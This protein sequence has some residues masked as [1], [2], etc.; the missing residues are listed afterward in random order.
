VPESKVL[1]FADSCI[2]CRSCTGGNDSW[3]NALLW[4]ENTLRVD[5]AAVADWDHLVERC[6]TQAL[7]WDSYDITVGELVAQLERDAVF[8]RNGGGITLSGGEPL[9][10]KDFSCAVLRA[11]KERGWGTAIETSLYADAATVDA[12]VPLADTVFADCKIRDETE[13]KAATSVSN[14]V[15]LDNL[16]R[17][18]CGEYAAR[19]IVRTPL[20]PDYTACEDNIAAI[21]RFISGLYPPVR[22]EL[23]NYNPLAAGKY[24]LVG[25]EYCFKENIAPY[26][27]ET[28]HHF[29]TIARANGIQNLL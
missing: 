24:P 8:Y 28:M 27:R 2:G 20:I 23:L 3:G 15:I 13:H 4:K 16:R 6:P 25:L 17:L 10:Q 18:L 22:Y 29:E 12:V 11:S 7:R 26:D 14:A 5:N 21:S 1:W 19:V 9:H